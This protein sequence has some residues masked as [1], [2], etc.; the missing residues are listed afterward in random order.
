MFPNS[1]SVVFA[2]TSLVGVNKVGT[3]KKT[4]EGYYPMVVGALNAFNSAGSYYPLTA[5]VRDLLENQSGSLQRRIKRGALR[6]EYGHPKPPPRSANREQ[7]RIQDEEFV[8]RN[9]SIYEENVCCHHMKL[10]L[11]DSSLKDKDGKA[12]IA[13]MSLV[14]PNGPKGE[15]LAK[16]LE[17]PNENVCFSIRSFTDNKTRFGIEERTLREVITFDYVNE[18]GISIAEKYLSP[19]LES[20]LEMEY[21]RGALE[22]AIFENRPAGISTESIILSGESLFNA[23]GWSLPNADHRPASLRW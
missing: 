17:N 3:L 22:R 1:N 21:S 5:Q 9:L 19:A 20:H 14:A 23:M 10:W 16:Q 4:P 8:R 15:V 12:V 18:P 13:I 2:C 7:Q 11:D 6:G